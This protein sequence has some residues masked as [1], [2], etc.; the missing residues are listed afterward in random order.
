MTGRMNST[1]KGREGVTS[2]KVGSPETS[3]GTETDHGSLCG[4]GA[5]VVEKGEG[6][7]SIQGNTQEKQISIVIS[8]ESEWG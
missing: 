5:T 1:M 2:K 3:F 8:L 4:K 6:Q 7:T